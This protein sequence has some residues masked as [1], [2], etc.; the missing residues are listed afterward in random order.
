MYGYIER[1]TLHSDPMTQ[2]PATARAAGL[3]FADLPIYF[4]GGA[5][6]AVAAAAQ[7]ELLLC[8]RGATADA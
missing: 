3:N 6:A 8:K 2:S 7:Q 5:A 1:E 4:S